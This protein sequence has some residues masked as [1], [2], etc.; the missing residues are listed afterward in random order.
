VLLANSEEEEKQQGVGEAFLQGLSD[1]GYVVGKT[2][3][4]E[5]RF[6]A[7]R[8]ERAVLAKE[9]IDAQVDVIATASRGFYAAARLTQTTPIVAAKAGDLV[10]Q[11]FAESLAHPGKNVTGTVVFSY[12]VLAKRLEVLHRIV[13]GLRRAGLLLLEGFPTNPQILEALGAAAK[14][15]DLSLQPFVVGGQKSYE[16]AFD[17]ARDASIGG[18]AIGDPGQFYADAKIIAAAAIARG[19]PT[20][21]PGKTARD[22]ILV[23]YGVDA[24]AAW[25]HAAA[26]VDKILK[27]TKPGEI[28]IER[29]SRFQIIVNLKTAAALK[30]DIPADV[31]AAADEVIE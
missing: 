10:A 27:G 25:R 1:L 18:V 7:D 23:G 16:T 15:A 12:E 8:D 2:V 19:L 13:P 9:L 20:A 6:G 31:L 24:V 11:G 29:A 17:A 3:L 14:A 28:P 30:L 4:V 22:G 5:A 21:G 26:F